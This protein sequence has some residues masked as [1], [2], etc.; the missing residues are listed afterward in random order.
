MRRFQVVEESM[1]PALRPGDVVLAVRDSDP[2]FGSIV[3]LPHPRKPDMWLIKR[4]TAQSDGELWVESDN[5][6]AT[7]ADSRTFGWVPARSIY[8][9]LWRI[10]HGVLIQRIRS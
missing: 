3:V 9:A 6:G 8:R 1:L 10:R 7:M 2:P 5:P 4:L